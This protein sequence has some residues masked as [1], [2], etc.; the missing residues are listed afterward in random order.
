MDPTF[1]SGGENSRSINDY[2]NNG[3]NYNALEFH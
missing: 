2:I 3:A 1:A